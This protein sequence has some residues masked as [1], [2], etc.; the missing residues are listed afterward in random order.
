MIRAAVI[1]DEIT[2]EFER[3]LDVMLEYGV[4]DAELRGLWGTNVMELSSEQVQR[5]KQALDERGMRVCGIASPLY[6]CKLAE[7]E[8]AAQGRLHLGVERTRDEQLAVL[9]RAIERARYFGTDLI[10]IFSFW[11]QGEMTDAVFAEIIEGLR[12]GVKLAES[13]GVVLGL[14]NE[15]ACFIGTGAEAARAVEAVASPAL[16][17][18][19]DPGNAYFAG[20]QPFPAGYEAVKPYVVHVHIK[21]AVRSPDGSPQWTVVGEGEIDYRAHAAAQVADGFEG[22]WSLETHYKA[23]S[24]STE[25]SSRQCLAGMLAV[26]RDAGAL[27]TD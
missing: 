11:R 7:T 21:D 22:I 16:K 25:E 20:E 17:A 6:K 2:Q 8:E 3:A 1:T 24:G 26:L 23:P 19:W 12:P 13:A 5:A 18:I 10:R 4:R 27:A 15:H 9:E 14:E